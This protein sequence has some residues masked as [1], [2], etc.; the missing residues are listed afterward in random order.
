MTESQVFELKDAIRDRDGNRCVDC[1]ITIDAHIEWFGSTLAVHRLEP[2]SEYTMEG[3]VT[4]CRLCHAKRH[5]GI[6]S[7]RAI[8]KRLGPKPRRY[9][10]VKIPFGVRDTISELAARNATNAAT[11]ARRLIREGLEREGLWPARK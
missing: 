10:S 7:P 2:G 4:V 9:L 1:S 11:E 3:C 6:N 8:A 5:R